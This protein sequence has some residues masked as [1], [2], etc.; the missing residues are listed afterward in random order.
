MRA[1]G[2]IG[3]KREGKTMQLFEST[4]PSTHTDTSR[5]QKKKLGGWTR[6]GMG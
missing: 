1:G 5:P 3:K 2:E 6:C 4:M